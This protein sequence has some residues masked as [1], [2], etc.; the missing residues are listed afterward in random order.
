MYHLQENVLLIEEDPQ[1]CK[2]KVVESVLGIVLVQQNK[3]DHFFNPKVI[4]LL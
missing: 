3:K 4:L 1:L 2:Y